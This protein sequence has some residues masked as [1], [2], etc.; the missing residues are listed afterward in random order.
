MNNFNTLKLLWKQQINNEYAKYQVF[1]NDSNM[2]KYKIN[3]VDSTVTKVSY[4]MQTLIYKCPTI[5]NVNMAYMING[6]K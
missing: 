1:I 2:P 6:Q 3:F 4:S 5:L